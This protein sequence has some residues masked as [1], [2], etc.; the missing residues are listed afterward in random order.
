MRFLRKKTGGGRKKKTRKERGEGNERIK[1]KRRE[2]GRP[3]ARDHSLHVSN[4]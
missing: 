2:E 4:V 1:F 3:E